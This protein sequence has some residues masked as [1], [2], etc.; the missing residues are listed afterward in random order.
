MASMSSLPTDHCD[1]AQ[2]VDDVSHGGA[3]TMDSDGGEMMERFAASMILSGVG[4]ALGYNNGQFEFE[5]SGAAIHSVSVRPSKFQTVVHNVV[6]W[7][8]LSADLSLRTLT[9]SAYNSE[10]SNFH[11]IM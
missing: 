4:D 9:W 11:K 2:Q 1:P 3:S 8:V 7:C 6:P 5:Y 10:I